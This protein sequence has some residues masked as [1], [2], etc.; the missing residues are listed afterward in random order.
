MDF[1]LTGDQVLIRDSAETVLAEISDSAAVR[2]AMETSTGYEPAVWARLAGELGWCATSIPERCGGL[3]LGPVE[4]ALLLEQ[5]GRRLL[6]APFFSTVCL[7]ANLLL[8]AGTAAACESYLPR[9][10][11]GELRATATLGEVPV[12]AR[13]SDGGWVLDGGLRKVLDGATAEVVFVFAQVAGEG[14]PAL[15]AIRADA[16]GLSRT[17]LKTWDQ[18]RR[19]ASIELR[20]L[21]VADGNRVDDSARAAAGYARAEAL[22]MLSLAAEQLGCAQQCLDLTL[23]YVANRKQFGRIIASFQAIKH[24]CAEMMVRIEATRSMVYGAAAF[25]AGAPSVDA[26][27]NECAAAKALASETASWCAQEAIQLHGGVGFT[28][29]YDPH[30][31]FKRAQ[32]A[33]QWLGVADSLRETI[34]A[35]LLD[36]GIAA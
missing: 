35:S 21:K 29:E 16:A 12:G 20:G 33:G 10:A 2:A 11:A 9:I 27:A 26:L 24:R 1:A 7:A 25:A 5:M 34:A 14:T 22:A 15:F 17:A 8:E 30:L 3:G 19:F 23:A 13:R 28:W 4:N 31:Y 18:T 32:A 6:C 36:T